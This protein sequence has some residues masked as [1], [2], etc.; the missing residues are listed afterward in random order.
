[1]NLRFFDAAGE[2]EVSLWEVKIDPKTVCLSALSTNFQNSLDGYTEFIDRSTEWIN[3]VSQ[4][5]DDFSIDIDELTQSEHEIKVDVD[6]LVTFLFDIDAGNVLSGEYDQDTETFT[7][8]RPATI[9]LNWS[10]F[11]LWHVFL[12]ELFNIAKNNNA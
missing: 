11:L 8:N 4:E 6:G 2:I 9:E 10:E 7:F 3:F 1:M 12:S 5:L